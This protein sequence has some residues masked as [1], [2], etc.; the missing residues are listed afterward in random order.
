IYCHLIGKDKRERL[1]KPKA[2][3]STSG[4]WLYYSL[5]RNTH[6][7]ECLPIS[8]RYSVVFVFLYPHISR[9]TKALVLAGA[10]FFVS[11]NSVK[12]VKDKKEDF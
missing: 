6:K 12:D 7:A 11:V 3:Q 9:N 1:I 10:S 5:E 8:I 4:F 2:R